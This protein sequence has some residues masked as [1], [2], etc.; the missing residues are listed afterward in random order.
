VHAKCV[1]LLIFHRVY[2]NECLSLFL[3]SFS[4][5]GQKTIVFRDQR[6]EFLADS[7]DGLEFYDIQDVTDAYHC[8]GNYCDIHHMV[9]LFYGV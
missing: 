2:L 3:Q 4:T 6:L 8:A 5:N 9:C 7:A 1:I